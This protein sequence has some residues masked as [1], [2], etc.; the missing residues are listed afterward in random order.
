MIMR[1]PYIFHQYFM[2]K[3]RC[4]MTT[5]EHAAHATRKR[6]YSPHYI[7]SNLALFQPEIHDCTSALLQ[8]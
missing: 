8:V 6:G 1:K 5:L 2:L 7:P 3:Q 4:R